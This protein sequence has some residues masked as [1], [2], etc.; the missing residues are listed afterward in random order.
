[1]VPPKSGGIFL[2]GWVP[3][4]NASAPMRAALALAGRAVGRT[5]P[6]PL[7]GA[8][9]V[10]GQRGQI[11][12]RGYHHRA[13]QPHAEVLAIAQA[14]PAARGATLYVTL[15]PCRH[16][17]HTPPCT[18]AILAAGLSRVVYA[19]PDPHIP[20]AGGGQVLQAAG[21]AVEVGDG[22]L[23][24]L[25][26]NAGYLS[27][28]V[29][30]RPWVLLK[31]AVSADGKVATVAAQS[32]Y[33][34]SA[35]ALADVHRLRNAVDAIVVGIG[36][37]LADDPA[38]TCRGVRGGRDPVRV[39]LDS[40]GRLPEAARV[41]GADPSR[42]S[43][44]P[45]LVYT[46][47]GTT[48]QFERRV[49]SRGGEVV[50]VDETEPGQLDLAAVMADLGERG[51]YTVLVEG[52]PTVHAALIRAGLADAWRTYWAPLV[53]GG[54][55]P[56]PVGGPGIGRLDAAP[57]LT[58]PRVTR[59]GVDVRLDAYFETSWKELAARCLPD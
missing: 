50:Q 30:R 8:V 57:R 24:A 37:V 27:W 7:V 46:G 25:A 26:Q 55:A 45:T 3:V 6:N 1:M 56:G 47:H 9:I 29:R 14:G 19:L 59:L 11:V 32:K 43:G 17:G 21:V 39:V 40:T 34:T 18:D 58:P 44:A 54:P 10:S 31:S 48:P 5:H 13:G 15:E 51:L 28:T 38:L 42:A 23:E 4:A 12:G 35:A 22:A 49:F 16:T 36:T 33:L 2:W 53:L 41:L 20:A 52:G